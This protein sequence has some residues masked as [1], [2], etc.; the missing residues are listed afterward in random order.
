[1]KPFLLILLLSIF[2]SVTAQ[3]IK[4][5]QIISGHTDT[6]QSKILGEKRAVWIHLPEGAGSPENAMRYPVVYLLDGAEFFSPV[7]GMITYLSEKNGNMICPDM[8]VVG[9]TNTDRTRDLTP[10]Y[11]KLDFTDK[12][13]DDFKTSGGGEKFTAFIEK[14]LIPHIDSIYPA[15]PFRMLVGHS[16][17]GLTA[18]NILINHTNLFNAYTIIDPSMWWDGKKL[19]KQAQEVLKQKDFSGRSVF[20]GIA[21]TMPDDMDTLH[22][23]HDTSGVNNHIRSILKLKDVFQQN[24]ANGLKWDYKYY[25]DDN[26]NSSPLIAEYD[27]FRFLFDYYKL[28]NAIDAKLYDATAKIDVGAVLLAHYAAISKH[29]GYQVLPPQ[30]ILHDMGYNFMEINLPDR[31]LAVFEMNIKYYPKSYLV[32]D[33]MGDYYDMKKDK[34]Q[35]IMYYKKSIAL[36]DNLETRNKLNKVSLQK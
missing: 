11:G 6:V 13:T 18:V 27:G 16:F 28:P 30:S 19:L 8:I 24:T 12:P 17:G 20:L 22:V 5:G 32:Y 2:S 23:R 1:M 36:K 10:T 34:E 4:N 25:K 15:A 21:N 31:A 3:D 35:A 29:M 14:E 7:T 9:I 26:H 33:S